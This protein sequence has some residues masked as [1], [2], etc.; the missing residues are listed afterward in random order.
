MLSYDDIIKNVEVAQDIPLMLK[1][2]SCDI[3]KGCTEQRASLVVQRIKK[4][5]A[6]EP[7]IV[8]CQHLK[9]NIFLVV[10]V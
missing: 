8:D 4:N 6:W 2:Y 1:E 5:L 7:N 9:C 3:H 10:F